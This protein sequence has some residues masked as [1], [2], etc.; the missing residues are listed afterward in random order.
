[1]TRSTFKV[2]SVTIIPAQ[3]GYSVAEFHPKYEESAHCQAYPASFE[4]RP[5]IAW[6]MELAVDEDRERLTRA[7]PV[8]PGDN[9]PARGLYGVDVIIRDP[10]GGFDVD[11]MLCADEGEALDICSKRHAAKIERAR[12]ESRSATSNAYK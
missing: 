4:Y 9:Y 10:D 7:I 11:G 5:L 2:E 12:C 3:P 6:R 8:V 1:M